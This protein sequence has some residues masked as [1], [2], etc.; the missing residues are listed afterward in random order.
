MLDGRSFHDMQVVN[1]NLRDIKNLG[2]VWRALGNCIVIY[3][4]GV[5][6]V[7]CFSTGKS[8]DSPLNSIIFNSSFPTEFNSRERRD[9]NLHA[10]L[11]FRFRA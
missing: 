9:A 11:H 3:G 7:R 5:V 1:R 6:A 2:T 8:G 10:I 4:S